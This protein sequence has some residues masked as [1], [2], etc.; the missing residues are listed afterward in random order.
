MP[1]IHRLPAEYPGNRESG[2]H[3]QGPLLSRPRSGYARV[4]SSEDPATLL[5]SCRQGPK[6][7]LAPQPGRDNAVKPGCLVAQ[8]LPLEHLLGGVQTFTD[9]DHKTRELRSSEGQNGKAP[10]PAGAHILRRRWDQY[11]PIVA[12][13]KAFVRDAPQAP[14]PAKCLRPGT[15]TI[16][17]LRKQELEQTEHSGCQMLYGWPTSVHRHWR[18]QV[19]VASGFITT[20]ALQARQRN[21]A[22]AWVLEEQ[23]ASGVE[24]LAVTGPGHHRRRIM[25]GHF[26]FT[27]GQLGGTSAYSETTWSASTSLFRRYFAEPEKALSTGDVRN[28]P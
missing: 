17:R 28:L 23:G 19:S 4:R 22:A 2:H 6:Q 27:S 7:Q 10:H 24:N 1:K 12:K 25:S 18:T 16:E 3:R 13:Q 11:I 21:G 14:A 20:I 26:D 5:V 15:L 8:D 9:S